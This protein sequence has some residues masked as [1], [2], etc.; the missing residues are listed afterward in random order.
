MKQ[1]LPQNFSYQ[2]L[3]K[4][5]VIYGVPTMPWLQMEAGRTKGD[6]Q[7]QVV[8]KANLTKREQSDRYKRT[9]IKLGE[10]IS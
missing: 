1:N 7:T 9:D 10:K 6:T 8:E 4:K 5:T 3:K 2:D